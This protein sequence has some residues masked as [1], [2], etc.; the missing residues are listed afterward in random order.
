VEVKMKD[1][2]KEIFL[3]G[4]GAARVTRKKVEKGVKAFAKK[5]LINNKESSE[6]INSMMS[7]VKKVQQ[8]LLREGKKEIKEFG[9]KAKSTGSAIKK[10]I[11][12]GIAKAA[13]E[14]S[15]L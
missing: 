2:I 10:K 11:S 1:N 3:I 7:E 9:K 8:E 13:A 15:K 12:K 6:L 5:K 14:Y 4:L